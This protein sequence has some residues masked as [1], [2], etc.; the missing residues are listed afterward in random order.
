MSIRTSD[1]FECN[2]GFTM[3]KLF[4]SLLTLLI[5]CGNAMIS[6]VAS[7]DPGDKMYIEVLNHKPNNHIPED[8]MVEATET[9]NYFKYT[10]RRF[11]F[12][13]YIPFEI[14]KCVLPV[15]G[16]GVKFTG[17]TCPGITVSGMHN[18]MKATV[19]SAYKE[20]LERHPE[21]AYHDSGEDWYVITY[22]SPKYGYIVYQKEF[23]NKKY[24]NTLNFLYP[25]ED[26][27]RFNAMIEV[28]EAHFVPG[29][30]TGNEIRG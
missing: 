18:V 4:C 13:A 15:N 9:P 21:A 19:E 10:N 24:I 27:E 2:E 7:A 28:I 30:K 3:R 11:G 12:T 8:L 22:Q 17:K 1:E 16:D 25:G 5:L 26:A 6:G 23:I 29:W 14:D 20:A